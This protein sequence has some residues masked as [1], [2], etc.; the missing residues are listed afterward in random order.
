MALATAVAMMASVAARKSRKETQ[1]EIERRR[2]GLL[3]KLAL[4]GVHW[5]TSL[6]GI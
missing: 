6:E 4:A 5:F 1:E 3:P 2:K